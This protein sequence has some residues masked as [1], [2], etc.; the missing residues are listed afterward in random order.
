MKI[1]QGDYEIQKETGHT[2]TH[3]IG[4]DGQ[5]RVMRNGK[6]VWEYPSCPTCGQEVTGREE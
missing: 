6:P 3:D 1:R 4:K 2:H 5:I